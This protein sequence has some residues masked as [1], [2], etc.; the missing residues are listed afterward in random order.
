MGA[1]AP[2]VP[3]RFGSSITRRNALAQALLS[4]G[5]D[6]YELYLD[7]RNPSQIQLHYRSKYA[8]AIEAFQSG[9]R[10]AAMSAGV[11]CREHRSGGYVKGYI[12]QA[13]G[14]RKQP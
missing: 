10:I 3:D 13:S 7:T 14:F 11:S 6:H 5:T 1:P 2:G 9:R 8:F 12:C 4:G